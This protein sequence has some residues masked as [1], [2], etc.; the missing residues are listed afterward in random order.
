MYVKLYKKYNFL[1]KL[2]KT[3]FVANDK[4]QQVPGIDVKNV[5]TCSTLEFER[6]NHTENKNIKKKNI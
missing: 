5:T 2:L 1:T 3:G 4:F 6:P